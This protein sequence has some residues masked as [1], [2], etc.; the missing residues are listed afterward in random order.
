MH[1]VVSILAAL[2]RRS[3]GGEAQ[4]LDVAAAEGVLSLMSLSVDQFLASGEVAGPR[5]VLLTGRYAF[6]DIYPC[7]DG[8]WVT[9]GAIE[10]HFYRNLCGFLGLK[11]FAE[12][13][14]DDS[15]QEEI[16]QAFRAA[17][18]TRD[19]DD[20][21]A[22]LAPKNTCVG[23]VYEIPELVEDPHFIE[24]D[25]FMQAEHAEHGAFRQVGP[26]LAGGERKQPEW[27]VRAADA[28]DAENILAGV[29]F[30]AEEINNL[31]QAGAVQ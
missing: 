23:P 27:K 6:Y 12:F 11:E 13:Q 24:R 22:E 8:K 19:R 17:F 1:A 16:R 9:V 28:S 20:W 15:R 21:V 14:M 2:V 5:Q 18:L 30:D 10:P 25:V 29:G 3:L 26:I 31:R 7:R 4:F